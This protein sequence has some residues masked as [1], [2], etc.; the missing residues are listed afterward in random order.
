MREDP[1]HQ[2]GQQQDGENTELKLS[3]PPIVGSPS[4]ALAK[5]ERYMNCVLPV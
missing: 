1:P 2:Q 4:C 5:P 3:A